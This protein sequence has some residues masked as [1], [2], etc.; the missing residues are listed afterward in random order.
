M[1]AFFNQILYGLDVLWGVIKGFRLSDALEIIIVAYLI[2][3]VIQIF[4]GTKATTFIKGVLL[5]VALRVI[6][7]VFKL[8]AINWLMEE[9]VF[10]YGIFALLIVFQPELR[11]MLER[12]GR[13]SITTFR[14][15]LDSSDSAEDM[16]DSIDAVCSAVKI[17]SDTKTG[18]L[19]VFEREVMLN[20]IVDTGT[21]LD[22]LAS[23][24][25]LCNIFYPKAPLH[26]G[27]VV[28]RYGR[29]LAAG[30]ILP[31]TQKEEVSRELGTRHRAALGMSENSDAVVVVVSEETGTVSVAKNGIL[32]RNYSPEQLRTEL[33]KSL[34]TAK[35]EDETKKTSLFSF[36]KGRKKNG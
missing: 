13:S 24:E 14:R 9:V 10:Q 33:E 11:K 32:R 31:L 15:A 28:M 6:A 8:D 26:D 30:C 1:Q 18:A 23:T 16:M 19:L 36:L 21:T 4:R 12:I 2:Y 5:V 35:D 7:I 27:A 29:V 25:S 3:K 34:L 17:M 20:D 22:A